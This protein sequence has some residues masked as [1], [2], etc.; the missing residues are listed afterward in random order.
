MDLYY[1]GFEAHSP[2]ASGTKHLTACAARFAVSMVRSIQYLDDAAK[3]AFLKVITIENLW[4]LCLIF[5]GWMIASI[6]GGPV[7]AAVNAILLYLGVREFYDRIHEIYT[8]LRDWFEQ[9]YNAKDDK[10]IDNAARSFAIGLANGGITVLEFVILHKLFKTTEKNL[11]SKFGP[12]EWL[13]EIWRRTVGKRGAGKPT[14]PEAEPKPPEKDK[15]GSA[16][17]VI[18]GS[19][20]AAGVRRAAGGFPTGAIVAGGLVA[21]VGVTTAIVVLAASKG[22]RR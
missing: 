6:I 3:A 11:L 4:A 16:V 19:L 2:V 17:P 13:R 1:Q 7:G 9:A 10:D 20:Q 18:A 5:A 14:V 15:A 12:P 21:A 8:P 22:E